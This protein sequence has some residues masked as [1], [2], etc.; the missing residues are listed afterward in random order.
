MSSLTDSFAHQS[1]R[2]PAKTLNSE[3]AQAVLNFPALEEKEKKLSHQKNE[4]G[5]I[6][7]FLNFHRELFV[8][9]L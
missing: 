8:R 1:L 3:Q 4:H 2:T 9:E 6:T 5:S 7:G